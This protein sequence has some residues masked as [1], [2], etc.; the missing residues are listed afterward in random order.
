LD[1][2]DA[3][4]TSLDGSNPFFSPDG[5]WVAVGNSGLVK[6]P[7]DGGSLTRIVS[8]ADWWLGATW[9]ADDTIVYATSAGLSQVAAGGGEA[10]RLAQPVRDGGEQLYAWPHFLPGGQSI[11]FTIVPKAAAAAAKIATMD[12][13][14]LEREVIIEGGSDARYLATGHLVYASEGG[15][16]VVP[17]DP[18]TRQL[19][20]D[21]RSVPGVEVRSAV[22]N[23]PADF[24]VAANGTLV[25]LPSASTQAPLETAA[26]G[27][28]LQWI[29]REG[30]KEAVAIKPGNYW[31]PRISPDG[32]RVAVEVF[33][34]GNRDI[35]IL[36]L[37]RSTLTQLTDGPTTD[38]VPEWSS[39]GS[40]VFFASDR[41][42]NHDVYSQAADGASPPTVEVAAPGFQVP[43]K[44]TPD[45]T[46]L[47]VGTDAV[48]TTDDLGVVTLGTPDRLEPL[49][50]SDAHEFAL[51]MSSDGRWIVYE[52]D[53]SGAQFEVFVRPFPDVTAG[54]ITISIDGGRNPLF[55]RKGD[56]IYYIELDG[57]MMAAAVTFTPTLE[58]GPAKKLFTVPQKS[59]TEYDVSPDGRFLI[60]EPAVPGAREPSMTNVA[61]VL[62]WFSELTRLAPAK[63]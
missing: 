29:D 5:K 22:A 34:P 20:G 61:V 31:R 26:W 38:M 18:D 51:D 25:F 46:R 13:E 24:A 15:L 43:F 59:A 63:P 62:D 42:G 36:D 8:D 50:Q 41:A 23:G 54:R 44:A 9:G 55:S 14:T 58:V 40:R 33:S 32:G 2:F 37:A 60:V 49:L 12:L 39:D 19:L 21:A 35:W 1:Q 4:A 27:H 52:S 17:F 10:R 47:I 6:M 11:L 57:D 48:G 56:E 16:K 30:N 28:T 45:G 7:A 53:E 3:V